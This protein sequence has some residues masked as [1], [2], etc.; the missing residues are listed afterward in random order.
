M[1]NPLRDRR[2][3]A[4]WAAAGQVIEIAEKLGGFQQLE[5][6]V[7][8]DLAALDVAKMPRQWRDSLIA[9]TLEFG[10]AD[11]RRQL[12]RVRCK[13]AASLDAVCQRCLEPFVLTLETEADLLL[14]GL[15]ET[16]EGYEDCEVW[17]LEKSMLRPLDIVEELLIM[18][19]PFSA[20]HVDRVSCTALSAEP[21]KQKETTTPFAAL[22]A[23]MTQ[24]Q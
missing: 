4:D 5:S 9:G 1:A 22:R 15:E 10:F 21:E 24:D 12:P 13:V 14:L 18:A 3:A 20:M 11:A 8:A 17:E 16:A 23:Q 19:L 6:I 2:T 7:G